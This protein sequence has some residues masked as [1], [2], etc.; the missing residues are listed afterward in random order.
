MEIFI[1][2]AEQLQALKATLAEQQSSSVRIRG[3]ADT[4]EQVAAQIAKIPSGLSAVVTMAEAV[5]RRVLDASNRV[6]ALRDGIPAIIERIERSDFGKSVDALTSDITGS[7]NDLKAFRESISKIDDLV[8]QFRVANEAVL[9]ELRQDSCKTGE[10]QEKVSASVYALRADLL[11]KLD[12][13]EKRIISTEQWSE[14]SI[15]ASGK[16]F[17]VIATALKGA[18]DRQSIALQGFQS[19]LDELK[20][21]EMV[22]IR[23]EL[24]SIATLILQQGAALDALSKKKGFSF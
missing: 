17:E 22:A 4:L 10:A 18:G 5:E 11:A 21:Q 14:K 8:Q 12:G 24:K 3:L 15:G 1:E 20:V 16:A 6:E 2:A 19:Q 23:K 9:N 7:R 13:M